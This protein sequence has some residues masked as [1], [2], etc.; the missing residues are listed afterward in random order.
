MAP[1][2]AV[3]CRHRYPREASSAFLPHACSPHTT[4]LP[5]PAGRRR[6]PLLHH[7]GSA[8][9]VDGVKFRTP[10]EPGPVSVG[11]AAV[12]CS[13]VAFLRP[14]T[15]VRANLRTNFENA[16][17]VEGS[18]ISILLEPA[19][20]HRQEARPTSRARCRREAGDKGHPGLTLADVLSTHGDLRSRSPTRG[21][22][23]G[24]QLHGGQRHGA[25]PWRRAI[26][27]AKGIARRAAATLF[28]ADEDR[29][30]SW[31]RGNTW[32]RNTFPQQ[33]CVELTCPW[34]YSTV[35][36]MALSTHALD[37]RER[38]SESERERESARERER[39]RAR[40]RLYWESMSMSGGPVRGANFQCTQ[41]LPTTQCECLLLN[42]FPHTA[43]PNPGH[44]AHARPPFTL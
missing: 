21:I 22:W 11:S 36:A 9:G 26:F 14:F 35:S 13:T 17:Q 39:E 28:F 8:L 34:V 10:S 30:N 12:N 1:G 42:Y 16:F 44:L 5:H 33:P 2:W 37:E 4:P 38:E 24:G 43:L 3:P 19:H 32:D 18:R 23:H 27:F 7:P 31:P 6:C 40:E 20:T 15:T 25:V 29:D 41:R